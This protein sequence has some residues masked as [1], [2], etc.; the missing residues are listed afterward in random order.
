MRDEDDVAGAFYPGDLC[1]GAYSDIL[2]GN[3]GMNS[4]LAAGKDGPLGLYVKD[5]DGNG[6]VEQ[7]RR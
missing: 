6:T 4:K 1:V 3:W 5:L 2:A 7:L